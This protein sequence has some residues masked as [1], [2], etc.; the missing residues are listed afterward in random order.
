MSQTVHLGVTVVVPDGMTHEEAVDAA[1]Q[2]LM[3]VF[4]YAGLEDGLRCR[5]DYD[6]SV[7]TKREAS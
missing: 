7:I 3:Q 5:I 4:R 6:V 1:Q 2:K